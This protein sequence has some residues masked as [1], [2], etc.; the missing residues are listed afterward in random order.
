MIDEQDLK[1]LARQ[2]REMTLR[3]VRDGVDYTGRK[4]SSL[5][6]YKRKPKYVPKDFESWDE[7]Y[8]R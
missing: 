5:N 8:L 3:M 4:H 2:R 6:S 7:A 1:N